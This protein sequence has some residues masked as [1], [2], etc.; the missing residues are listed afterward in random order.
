ME[1]VTARKEAASAD[2]SEKMT[3]HVEAW[4]SGRVQGVGFRY[5]TTRV[6]REYEVSGW[7]QNLA[8][9]R[10]HLVA[11]G[12]RKEVIGFI[13]G[14]RDEMEAYIRDVELREEEPCQGVKGFTIQG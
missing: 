9:G 11:E 12:L 3:V 7:V 10:V 13:D 5:Q 4:F 14:I 8:D 6:A 2:M 1:R